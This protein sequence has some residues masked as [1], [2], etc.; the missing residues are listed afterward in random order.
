MNP[1]D[2]DFYVSLVSLLAGL[3][4]LFV[5]LKAHKRLVYTSP[6]GALVVLSGVLYW[7]VL[8]LVSYAAIYHE[9]SWLYNKG[10]TG[11]W[12][13]TLGRLLNALCWIVTLV[14]VCFYAPKC[15]RDSKFNL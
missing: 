6:M 11:S 15:K 7:G 10:W 13:Y 14:F 3:Y 5:K 1:I 12:G 4:V 8:F 9:P 2:Y